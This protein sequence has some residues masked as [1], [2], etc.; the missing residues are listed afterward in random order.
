M[1]SAG[2]IM[3][4]VGPLETLLCTNISACIP[5]SKLPIF[6]VSFGRL[7]A[8]KLSYCF[9]YLS[10]LTFNLFTDC[11]ERFAWT[12]ICIVPRVILGRYLLRVKYVLGSVSLLPPE[13]DCDT[14]V[15]VLKHM[16]SVQRNS[17]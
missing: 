2:E 17:I 6:S 12:V 16:R 13:T 15:V 14:S 8:E 7:E 5:N 10:N 11:G 9:S 4:D 1:C 3:V